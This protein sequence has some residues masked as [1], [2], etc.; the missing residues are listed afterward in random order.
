MRMLMRANLGIVRLHSGMYAKVGVF[1][2]VAG[3]GIVHSIVGWMCYHINS[4]SPDM[5]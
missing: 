4:T 3:R 2:W 1:V 5:M